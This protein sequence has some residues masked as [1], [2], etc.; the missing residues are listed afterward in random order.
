[1]HEKSRSYCN[2][3][4]LYFPCLQ[5]HFSC[6][7]GTRCPPNPDR[8]CNVEYLLVKLWGPV[9]RSLGL[10]VSVAAILSLIPGC[11]GGSSGSNGGGAPSHL[12]YPQSSFLATCTEAINPDTPTVTGTVTGYS[13]AP[14]LPKGLA[15]DGTTGTI[16]GTPTAIS[17]LTNYT[18]T[19]SN[20]SG[21]TT[22]TVQIR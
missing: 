21:S 19:A 20:S 4:N 3:A 2:G 18:V 5:L 14:A 1:M 10:C 11:N 12:A 9:M 17:P 13:I 22:A 6:G 15:L 7:I 8:Y 16:S